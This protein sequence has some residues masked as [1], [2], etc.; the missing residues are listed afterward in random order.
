MLRSADVFAHYS[1]L[2]T[3]GML[4]E[5]KVEGRG[6]NKTALLTSQ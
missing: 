2:G 6:A 3:A 5:T 4:L 1:G